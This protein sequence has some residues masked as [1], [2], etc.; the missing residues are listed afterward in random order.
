MVK[1]WSGPSAASAAVVVSSLV[2][3]AGTKRPASPWVTPGSPSRRFLAQTG[4]HDADVP[5]EVGVGERGGDG[6]AYGAGRRDDRVVRR[7][8]HRGRLLRARGA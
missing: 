8:G 1:V 7:G 6:A 2:V 4:D 5:T 3:L